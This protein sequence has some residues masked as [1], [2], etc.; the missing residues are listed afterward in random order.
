MRK[1][2][3]VLASVMLAACAST[4]VPADKLANSQAAVRSAEEM[5]AER[6]PDAAL[7]LRLAREQL[8]DAKKKIKDGD[9]ERAT[10]VL[11]RAQAD[12]EVALNLAREAQTRA[13]AQKTIESVQ[14]IKAQMEGSKS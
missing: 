4:P 5:N 8:D 7:Y 3:F 13:D 6:N 1:I 10:Y 12:A 11:A 14:Q 9:N 2:A